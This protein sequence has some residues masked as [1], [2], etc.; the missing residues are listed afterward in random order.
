MTVHDFH[1]KIEEDT[2]KWQDIMFMDEK[3]IVKM[4]KLPK[5]DCRFNIISMK[6]PMASLT[7]IEDMILRFLR[8]HKRP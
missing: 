2:N 3:N 6:I 4:S 1:K 8:G 7:E 5:V